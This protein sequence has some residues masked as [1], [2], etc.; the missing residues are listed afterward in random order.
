MQQ[1]VEQ[2]KAE[3]DT[4]KQKRDDVQVYVTIQK[5]CT[6]VCFPTCLHLMKCNGG[7]KCLL[8]YKISGW[9]VPNMSMSDYLATLCKMF[10]VYIFRLY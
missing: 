5:T 2:L 7:Q 10:C 6:L 8:F 1:K 4:F 3:R 9:C